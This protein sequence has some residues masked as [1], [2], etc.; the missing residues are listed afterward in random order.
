V[1]QSFTSIPVLFQNA[2]IVSRYFDKN[3]IFSLISLLVLVSIRFFTAP[4]VLKNFDL[5]LS[6]IY[7]Y[8][9]NISSYFLFFDFGISRAFLILKLNNGLRNLKSY[10]YSAIIFYFIIVLLLFTLF[11]FFHDYVLSN[12]DILYRDTAIFIFALSIIQLFFQF[13]N[14]LFSALWESI[15]KLYVSKYLDIISVALHLFGM[16]LGVYWYHSLEA[17]FLALLS[18]YA[19]VSLTHF[20]LVSKE[21]VFDG[22]LVKIEK[23]FFL[24]LLQTGFFIVSSGIIVSVYNLLDTTL[25]PVFLSIGYVSFYSLS[26]NFTKLIH[27]VTGAM[28]SPMYIQMAGTGDTSFIG[29]KARHVVILNVAFCFVI[30]IFFV[31]FN[32]EILAVWVNENFAMEV[33]NLVVLLTIS[34]AFH[35]A[36]IAVHTYN[37]ANNLSRNNLYSSVILV[38]VTTFLFFFLGKYGLRGFALARIVGTLLFLLHIYTMISKLMDF[39]LL[40]GLKRVFILFSLLIGFLIYLNDKIMLYELFY[41]RLFIFSFFAIVISRKYIYNILLKIKLM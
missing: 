9:L 21:G 32:K 2:M 33:S 15:G 1:W 25:I 16:V 19:L 28:I 22:L 4:F 18:A 39:R 24:D 38:F 36:C 29:D 11:I 13:L 8:T 41:V 34:W 26:L 6:G 5:S 35:G 37:E 3:L 27:T 40:L 31:V 10:F 17:L 14:Q 23:R 20:V 12:V 7:Y 30:S